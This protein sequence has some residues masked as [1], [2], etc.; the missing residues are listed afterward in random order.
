MND[1]VA[2]AKSAFPKCCQVERCRKE[3]CSASMSDGPSNRAIIDMDCEAIVE[4]GRKRCDYLLIGADDTATYVAPIELKSGRFTGRTVVE[5]LR[6]RQ[7]DGR[8]Q[9]GAHIADRWLPPSGS[10]RF[11]PTLAHGRGVH[12]EELRSLRQEKVAMRG[13]RQ[14]VIAIRC[15]DPIATALHRSAT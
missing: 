7:G 2:V 3:G 8:S 1:L 12:R 11:V 5:Q 15:G 4:P 13:K 6:P 10:F 14:Q 9:A